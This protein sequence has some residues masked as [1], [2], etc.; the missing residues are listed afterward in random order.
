MQELLLER[1]KAYSKTLMKPTE[2]KT[3]SELKDK[4]DELLDKECVFRGVNKDSQLLPKLLREGDGCAN[5]EFALLDEFEQYYGLFSHANNYWEFLSIAEHYGLMTR[6]IDFSWNPYVALFFALYQKRDEDGCYK[7]YAIK[8]S[9]LNFINDIVKR[10]DNFV[11]PQPGDTFCTVLNKA[12]NV[13]VQQYKYA[14][15]AI[16]PSFRTPRIF[17]QQGLFVVPS[18][19]K[20]ENI[21]ELFSDDR[22]EVIFIPDSVREDAKK[23]LERIG[24]DEAHLMQD[25]ASVCYDINNKVGKLKPMTPQEMSTVPLGFEDAGTVE[26]DDE[27]DLSE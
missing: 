20:K 14:I 18:V 4:F 5:K 19:L 13:L 10:D 23:Y 1:R 22:T 26:I 27:N 21:V 9:D 2:V 25:L 7:I 15:N 8:R 12:F 11:L 16:E 6:L 24:F 17:A 3:F